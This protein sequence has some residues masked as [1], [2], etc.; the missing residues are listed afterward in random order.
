MGGNVFKSLENANVG[1]IKKENIQPT[2]D[3]FVEE[4][5]RIFPAAAE[6]LRSYQTLGSVGKKEKSGDID[7]TIDISHFFTKNGPEYGKWGI[8]PADYESLRKSIESRAKTASPQ[9]IQL[10]A[11]LKIIADKI[12]NESDIMWVNTKSTSG[13]S[14]H[15]LF[16]QFKPDGN[17]IYF[18]DEDEKIPSELPL[19]VQ[20]DLMVGNQ[21]WLAFSYYSDVYQGNVKGLH[22]TQL[23]L[24]TYSYKG[25]VFAHGTGIKNKQTNEMVANTPEEAIKLLNE[26]YGFNITPNILQNY[27]KLRPFL[28]ENL[29]TEDYNGIID[30]FLKIL[31]ST[32]TDIPDDLQQYWIENQERLGLKGKFLPDDSNLIKYKIL[33]EAIKTVLRRIL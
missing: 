28:E 17:L 18:S 1:K 25:Y 3:K 8:N 6:D 22:R 31:D 5:V 30:I 16:P 14:L 21:Q 29:S 12:E 4:M 32:R 7:L 27:F 20:L 10:N 24:A 2:I 9:Q 11:I 13:G 23:M 26:L 33:Q 19:N 15:F